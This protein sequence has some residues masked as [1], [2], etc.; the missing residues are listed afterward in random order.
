MAL[1]WWTDSAIRGQWQAGLVVCAAAF[2]TF[3]RYPRVSS[4][5]SEAL[6]KGFFSHGSQHMPRQLQG[7]F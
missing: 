5:P 1:G 2:L 3:V 7:K 4:I 6:M